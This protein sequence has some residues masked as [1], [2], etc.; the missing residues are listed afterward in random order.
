MSTMNTITNPPIPK[1]CPQGHTAPPEAF[2]QIKEG[3][4]W[5]HAETCEACNAEAQAERMK[6]LSIAG[7]NDYRYG[8]GSVPAEYRLKKHGGTTDP[9]HPGFSE[10]KLPTRIAQLRQW[11]KGSKKWAGIVGE[12]GAA[13]SRAVGVFCEDLAKEGR[14]ILWVNGAQLAW[15]LRG[16]SSWEDKVKA[17]FHIKKMISAD[18]LV[19]DDLFKNAAVNSEKY[20]GGLYHILEQRN[21]HCKTILWTANTHPADSV[22]KN[23]MTDDQCAPI[24]GRL[25]ENSY[26]IN[27]YK[28]N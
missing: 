5:I 13:K 15:N 16:G 27:L 28:N 10:N 11:N 21:M 12:G 22:I 18:V 20:F 4:D 23:M 24:V 17:E 9:A 2:L 8:Q 1:T 25:I 6:E 26:L 14:K 3:G 19:L 7:L